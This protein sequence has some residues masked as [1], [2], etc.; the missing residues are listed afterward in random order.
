MQHVT[1]VLSAACPPPKSCGDVAEVDLM[2]EGACEAG[3]LG[4]IKP[5]GLAVLRCEIALE[6]KVVHF[7]GSVDDPFADALDVQ[8]FDAQ[9]FELGLERVEASCA[10]GAPDAYC[11]VRLRHPPGKFCTN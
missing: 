1:E 4:E 6:K 10:H 8:R 5:S 2:L 7:E 3:N 11:E 9:A